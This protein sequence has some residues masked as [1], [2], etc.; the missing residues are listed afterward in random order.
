[1]RRLNRAFLRTPPYT[2]LS[3]DTALERW[4]RGGAVE[5]VVDPEATARLGAELDRAYFAFVDQ[6][7]AP[8][9]DDSP[10]E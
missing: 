8:A 7:R 3:H 1:L 5:P 10:G 2:G 9:R 4:L 6:E